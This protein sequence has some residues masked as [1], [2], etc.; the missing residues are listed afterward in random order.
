ML[1]EVPQTAHR[2]PSGG[3]GRRTLLLG[4]ALVVLAVVGTGV[5]SRLRDAGPQPASGSSQQSSGVAGS[6]TLAERGDPEERFELPDRELQGF[7]DAPGMA[8]S[9]LRGA[10]AVINFWATWCASCVKEMPALQ[11]VAAEVEGRVAFLGVN[12]QDAPVNA[13]SFA[14]RLDISFP[15]ATDPRGAFWQEVGGFG[16]PT[17]L[18]VNSR[19][20]VVYRHTGALEADELRD[21]L[22]QRLGIRVD[23]ASNGWRVG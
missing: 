11:Q 6:A 4:L 20:M 18:L 1:D 7:D 22:R 5:A 10:P 2:A 17:T 15:L 8:L 19:G 9:D 3:A 12:V 14:E 16:M 13:I 21:L 23:S